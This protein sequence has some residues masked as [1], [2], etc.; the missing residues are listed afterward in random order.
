MRVP[1]K[2]KKS[3]FQT[4]REEREANEITEAGRS[5]QLFERKRAKPVLMETGWL[6]DGFCQRERGTERGK[7]LRDGG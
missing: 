4:V 5:V 2:K 6:P 1:I 7:W 3:E